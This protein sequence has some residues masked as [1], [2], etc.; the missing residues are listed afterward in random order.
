FNGYQYRC[1]VSNSGGSVN[2]T[3]ATLVVTSSGGLPTPIFTPSQVV[4]LNGTLSAAYPAGFNVQFQWTFAPYT[5]GGLPY[6]GVANSPRGVTSANVKTAG[7]SLSLA[8][9]NLSAGPYTITVTA[10][11]PNT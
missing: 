3:V 6:Y 11:D 9:M 7:A 5:G 1:V 4:P 8:G 10:I 2:S